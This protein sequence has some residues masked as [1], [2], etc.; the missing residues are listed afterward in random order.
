MVP[1]LPALE[2][3]LRLL[4]SRSHFRAEIVRKL[5][6]RG[7]SEDETEAAA[8]RLEE[9]SYLDDARTARELAAVR[10]RRG[11]QGARRLR[12][13]L[14]ARGAAP[15]LAAEVVAELLPDDDSA[16]AREAARLWRG[17]GGRAGLARHLERRG[18]SGR[19]ILRALETLASGDD[20]FRDPPPEEP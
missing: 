9:L 12:A 1:R 14:E 17:R 19:G 15:E 13:D 20:D 8:R 10:L 4:A 18:F 16:L 11:A 5:A 6:A 3:A 2:Q 7:Y